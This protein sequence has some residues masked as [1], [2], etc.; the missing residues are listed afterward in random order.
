MYIM[1]E[2]G[3][4]RAREEGGMEEGRRGKRAGRRQRWG[5]DRTG[6]EKSRLVMRKQRGEIQGGEEIQ[7][8]SGAIERAGLKRSPQ[9]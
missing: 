8:V 2:R 7:Q 9:I 6:Q 1:G 5:R 3:K 4:E